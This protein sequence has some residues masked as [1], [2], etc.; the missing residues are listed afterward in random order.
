MLFPIGPLGCVYSLAGL[1]QADLHFHYKLNGTKLRQTTSLR[2][3][4]FGPSPEQGQT[5]PGPPPN[6]LNDVADTISIVIGSVIIQPLQQCVCSCV[7]QDTY[8][9]DPVKDTNGADQVQ[10]FILESLNSILQS[11]H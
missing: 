9:A 5:G 7:Y 8:G 3:T 4:H 11:A 10:K 2:H 6:S 1:G